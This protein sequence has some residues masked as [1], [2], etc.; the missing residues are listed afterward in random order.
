MSKKKFVYFFGDSKNTDGNASM[1]KLLGGKGANLAE[2]SKLNIPV[3]PGFTIST[4]ACIYYMKHKR[5]PEE[6]DKQ[7]ILGLTK[8]ELIM[9]QKFGSST[10][11]LLVSVRSGARKSMPGMMETVLNVG[12]T[13]KTIQGLIY[14][15]NNK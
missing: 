10:N 15:T 11:P 7:I 4:D 5:L 2:M 1:T 8:I 14:Q 13:N 3:P 9:K 12:L 6:C